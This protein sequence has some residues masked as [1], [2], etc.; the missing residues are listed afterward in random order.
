[1]KRK[2]NGYWTKERLYAE[3]LKYK[4]VSE[5]K[6]N[7]LT[8]YTLARK[9]GYL[10]DCKNHMVCARGWH[11]HGFWTRKKCLES[12]KKYSTIKEWFTQDPRAY[13]AAHK[14]KL[15]KDCTSHMAPLGNRYYRALYAFEHPDKS[16]YVGLT[17][18]YAKRYCEHMRRNKILIEK[19]KQGGQTFRR[20]NKFYPIKTAAE[21][22][23]KL[24]EKY[25]K[26]G[27][28]I[29]NKVSHGALGKGEFFWTLERCKKDARLYKHRT[30]W[31]DHSGGYQAARCRG[32]LDVCC[33]HMV[34]T[35][36]PKNYW[37]ID[38]CIKEAKK[39]K[40]IAPW[41]AGSPASYSKAR[42]QKWLNLCIKHMNY[43]NRLS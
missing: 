16:V 42:K 15:I 25:R 30:E 28:T 26:N 9:R 38:K 18:N 35:N 17:Y 2:P 20:F 6:K 36:K 4:T 22:E 10:R 29:L 13:Y 14:H 21:R 40:K 5:W 27:W 43:K 11:P 32:W 1:M 3:A 8:S 23:G 34:S 12:A 33:K 24:I 37:T 19:K 39:Y 31:N 7:N 41:Q